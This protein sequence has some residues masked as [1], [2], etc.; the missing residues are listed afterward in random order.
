M[1]YLVNAPSGAKRKRT[2]KRKPSAKQLK[3]RKKFAAMSRARAKARRL[4][5][6]SKTRRKGAA[7]MAAKK[8]TRRRRKT[9]VRRAASPQRRK[10]RVRRSRV[11]RSPAVRVQRRGRTV[12]ASNGRRR[13]RYRRNPGFSGGGILRMLQTAG[14]DAL[15]VIGGLAGTNFVARKIPFGEGNKGIEAAKKAAVAVLLSMVAGK[16]LGRGVGEKVLIGG[17]TAVGIDLLRNVPQLG[18][19]L[20]GDD[21]LRYIARTGLSAYA[22]P[23]AA[24]GMSA[25]PSPGVGGG[26]A[27]AYRH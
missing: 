11:R 23:A 7:V 10:R 1:I 9:T 25:Y 13:R 20:A 5:A 8:S 27:A 6:S 22:L 2:A 14:K 16:A 26:D 3:A 15:A 24:P 17:I 18:T 21:D 19:A 12:Y 4:A